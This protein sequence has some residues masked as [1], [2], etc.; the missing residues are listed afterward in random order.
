MLFAKEH[1]KLSLSEFWNISINEFYTLTG[2]LV[3]KLEVDP[4]KSDSMSLDEYK[5]LK[6]K[7]HGARDGKQPIKDKT[8]R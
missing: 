8:G 6:A 7:I 4:E 3:E 2:L 5:K 1:L